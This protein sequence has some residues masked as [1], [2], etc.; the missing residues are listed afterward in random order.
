GGAKQTSKDMR[1]EFLGEIPLDINIRINSDEG[2][3][4]KTILEK[5]NNAV[6]FDNISEHLISFLE[7]SENTNTEGPII[8]FE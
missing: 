2:K 4:N 5:N 8:K 3:P 1:I 7:K 6:Y